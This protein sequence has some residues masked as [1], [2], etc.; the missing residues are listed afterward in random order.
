M[1]GLFA[2]V[3]PDTIEDLRVDTDPH[4]NIAYATA[5]RAG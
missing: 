2:T 1:R 5:R 4:T 3:P